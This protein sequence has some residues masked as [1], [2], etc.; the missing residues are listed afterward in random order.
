[1]VVRLQL[2]DVCHQQNGKSERVS[3][4][5]RERGGVKGKSGRYYV[6]S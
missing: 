1:M 4:A 6:S 2:M 5:S 3:E